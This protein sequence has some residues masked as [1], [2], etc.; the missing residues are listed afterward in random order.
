[1]GKAGSQWRLITAACGFLKYVSYLLTP[2]KPL[3]CRVGFLTAYH[4]S[5]VIALQA[6]ADATS[7]VVGR[8]VGLSCP[9]PDG[10]PQRHDCR[11][12]LLRFENQFV[13]IGGIMSDVSFGS[14]PEPEKPKKTPGRFTKHIALASTCLLIMAFI[15]TEAF[16]FS[17]LLGRV[18]LLTQ[19]D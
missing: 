11:S 19:P 7:P 8:Q 13:T 3:V 2:L 18:S 6:C 15:P 1:M 16:P 10:L 17:L 12:L 4:S 14:A 9:H 5:Y